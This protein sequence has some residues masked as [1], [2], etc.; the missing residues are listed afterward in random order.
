MTLTRP[1]KT[2]LIAEL[3]E[4]FKSCQSVMFSHYIGMTVGN[5][6]AFRKQLKANGAEMKVAK[7]TLM[8]LAAKE[9]GFPVVEPDDLDGP[10]ACIFSF[11]DPLSG[12]QAAFKFGKEHS[13]IKLIGGIYDGKVLSKEQAMEMAMMPGREQLLAMFMSMLRAPLNQFAGMCASPLGGFARALNQMSEKGGFAKATPVA[14][15]PK[16][17]AAPATPAAE[18][19]AA[20]P[21]PSEETPQ[22]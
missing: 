18:A 19:P 14:E 8:A 2:A 5:V 12:A 21:A 7:K 22:A 6:S 4:K 1:Q 15:A 11:E 13:Q 3:V 20:E 9:A 16:M 17:E 10:V